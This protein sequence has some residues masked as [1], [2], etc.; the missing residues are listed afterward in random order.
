MQ[1]STNNLQFHSSTCLTLMAF[2]KIC[3]A[4]CMK[5]TVRKINIHVVNTI[6]VYYS[7]N[8]NKYCYIKFVHIIINET[9]RYYTFSFILHSID[10][11]EL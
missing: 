3:S 6:I 2:A 11:A 8:Y 1:L 5:V 10:S 9:E 4:L 7:P